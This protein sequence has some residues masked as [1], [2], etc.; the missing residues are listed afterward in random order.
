MRDSFIFYRSFYEATKELKVQDQALVYKA[1]F[2]YV[3]NGQPTELTGISAAVFILIKPQ[4]DANNKRYQNGTLGGEHGVKGGRPKKP[5][6]NPIGVYKKTP[7]VNDNVNVNDNEY[8]YFGYNLKTKM[9]DMEGED[10]K[11]MWVIAHCRKALSDYN[12]AQD[13]ERIHTEDQKRSEYKIFYDQQTLNLKSLRPPAF[14][15][16]D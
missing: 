8:K 10:E 3:L 13:S 16:S 9:P 15:F 1:I 12:C 2:E 7:N 6:K 5:Q 4:L 14:N 11:I